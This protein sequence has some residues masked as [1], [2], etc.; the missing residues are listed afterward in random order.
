MNNK[1]FVSALAKKTN[2]TTKETQKKIEEML[3]LFVDKLTDDNDIVVHGLGTF[4]VKQKNE[5]IMANPSTGKKLLV[6][7]KRVLNLKVSNT[8]KE[9][10]KQDL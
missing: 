5:R 9:K 10:V 8:L 6:P 3:D 7:P 4:E 1:D 2:M